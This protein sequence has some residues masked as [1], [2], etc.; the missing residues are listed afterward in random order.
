MPYAPRLRIGR[1]LGSTTLPLIAT[2]DEIRLT[3]GAGRNLALTQTAPWPNPGQLDQDSSD[4][5][6]V[7]IHANRIGYTEQTKRFTVTKAKQGADGGAGSHS[8][9]VFIYRRATSIPALPTVVSTYTFN[10]GA[11]SGLDNGWT[12]TIPAGTDPL[13]VSAAAANDPGATDTIA[14]AEWASP[15]VFS[16]DGLSSAMIFLFQR[17]A[18]STLPAV[19]GTTTTYTFATAVLSGA[20][21]GWTQT[22]PAASGGKY[23]FVTTATALSTTGTDTLAT[24]EWAVVRIMAQDGSSGTTGPRGNVNISVAITGTAVWSDA[25]AV[26]GLIAAGYGAPQALDIVTEYKSAAG[27]SESRFFDGAAWLVVTQYLNGNLFVDGTI[28]AQK[29][30]A[31]SINTR[32]LFVGSATVSAESSIIGLTAS[33]QIGTRI[34]TPMTDVIS[35]VSTGQ[36][37][38]FIA[39][40]EIRVASSNVG[41]NNGNG[42]ARSFGVEVYLFI[43]GIA[44]NRFVNAGFY[45]EFP[46]AVSTAYSIKEAGAIGPTSRFALPIVWRGVLPSGNHKY[47]LQTYFYTT[48]SN[49]NQNTEV[50]ASYYINYRSVAQENKV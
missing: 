21:G 35:L 27:F 11:I 28:G 9:K 10:T 39:T 45:I 36:A 48:S 26:A 18:S 43:D 12:A 41:D 14:A 38:S 47:S 2:L 15:V 31:N 42:D 19:P 4:I 24:T 16:Q 49:G 23:L 33:N 1:K 44:T 3:V 40:A 46:N 22:V 13:Y 7:D 6:W 20:L 50:G 34:A 29:I 5:G 8:A 17:S 32:E 25:A 37:V 30:V